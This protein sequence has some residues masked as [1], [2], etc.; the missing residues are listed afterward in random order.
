MYKKKKTQASVNLNEQYFNEGPKIMN[1]SES[2]TCAK[3]VTHFRDVFPAIISYIEASDA[4]IGC[5][6][7]LTHPGVLNA[8]KKKEVSIVV[9]KEDWMRPDKIT[10]RGLKESIAALNPLQMLRAQ[11][12]MGVL[13][14]VCYNAD[15]KLDEAVRCCGVYN[16]DKTNGPRM[17]N[18]FLVFLRLEHCEEPVRKDYPEGVE[19]DCWFEQSCACWSPTYLK[20]YAVWTGSVNMTMNSS[21][22]L[23]NGVYIQ[24][25]TIAEAYMREYTQIFALSEPLDWTHKYCAPEFRVGT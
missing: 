3:V 20:P 8:F 9:N 11:E 1:N 18:K 5:V 17:H 19:G 23:E 4:V 2:S 7:W 15:I 24:D 22:S 12:R 13:D 16:E 14:G 25:H 21:N 10:I 6:A